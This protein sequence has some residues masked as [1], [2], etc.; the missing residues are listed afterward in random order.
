[1]V[2]LL[3]DLDLAFEQLQRLG[4]REELVF[5]DLCEKSQDVVSGTKTYQEVRDQETYP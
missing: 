1:M 4:I 5:L 3:H 2:Q